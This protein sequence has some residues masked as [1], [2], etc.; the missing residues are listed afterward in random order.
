MKGLGVIGTSDCQHPK[1]F[2][3]IKNDL[4]DTG[5]GIYTKDGQNFLCSTE[6]SLIYSQGGQGRRIHNLVLF[7]SRDCIPQFQEELLKRG[8]ID[9]DGRPIFKIPCPEFVDLVRGIDKDS[10]VI[11]AHVWTP[12]FSLFGSKSGFDSV[13]E[14][15]NDRAKFI[16]CLETGLSSDPIMNWRLSRNDKYNLVSFSDAHSHWPWRIGRECTELEIKNMTYGNVL[17]ALRTNKIARTIEFFPEEGKYHVDGHRACGIIFT[18]EESKKNE[19]IC[20]KCL[21]PLTI[22]VLNRVESL[23]D[24]SQGTKAPNAK[25]FL[26][27]LPLAE[28][29]GFTLGF[30]VGHKNVWAAYTKIV[31]A[32]GNEMSAVLDG[33]QE[34]LLK[35]ASEKI[36]RVMLQNRNQ[37]LQFKPGYDGVYGVP[38]IEGV[39]VKIKQ[40]EAM[41]DAKEIRELNSQRSIRSKQ[42]TQAQKNLG[43]F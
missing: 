11:P 25:P 30:P 35:V 39:E 2:L 33:T 19:G 38:I 27:L 40:D 4:E 31:D 28:L 32:F 34:Q 10:E 5:T 37:T 36:V 16:H 17:S 29:L 9:Y 41:N 7:P 21:K 23:A 13:E 42:V 15:F 6:I 24:R 12:W 22:G 18:P 26:H 1:W 8:R 43:D 14:C 3:E 20:P